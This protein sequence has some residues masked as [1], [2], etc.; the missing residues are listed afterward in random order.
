MINVSLAELRSRLYE[1]YDSQHVGFG[2]AKAAA[3]VHRRGIRPLL[4]SAAAA[5]SIRQLAAAADFDSALT[6]SSPPV[7]HG[8]ACAAQVMVW[9]V[10]S[11]CYQIPLAA[12]TGMP[13][14]HIA[15]LNLTF[16][17]RKGSEPV[18][19]AEEDPA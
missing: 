12:E 16:A 6:R 8:L 17:A 10:V 7:V 18:K 3:L 4:P 15:T 5:R 13:R 19:P 14:G 11:A 1:T 9:Q 2:G